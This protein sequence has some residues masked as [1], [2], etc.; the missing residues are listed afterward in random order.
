MSLYRSVV[1]FA[2]GLREYTKSGYE[3]ACKDF[4]PHDLEVQIP[5][6]VFL[7]TGGNSGIGKATALEIAKRGGTVHLVCRDQAPAEDARGEII[8]ESGNQNI[9]LH[10]VDLSDPKQI[11]KFV[12]N[13]KQEHKLHVLINNAGCMVN[14]R[15]LT[16]D[17]LE[18]NFAANT[19]GVYILT[20]GLIPVLEKE[21]DPR[22][23]TV[24]S[25]GMLVQKLNT[26]DLQ[27]ERTPFDGTMVY[28]QN[29]RQQ[30]V[31]T[32]RWA[33]GHPAIHFSSMHP[34][35]AD[36]PGVRQAMP[37]FHAR[38]GDR[39]RSEAQGADTMLWLALSSAAA[40]QPSGR[41]FQDRKP[42]ST[43]LP[44]ATASSSPAEE[45]KLIEILEQ[46]AQ[47]FK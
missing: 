2:K 37:G 3:S 44:L 25:G 47:T 20:T 46:L 38:F 26:N 11:W 42:V 19:L 29:K 7:V 33:Q 9:F 39:L 16:E 35:W 23:I 12:E 24:S 31:L 32:E 40:A 45:E 14:K 34:G 27:S 36:T 22:V 21:H 8:R 43:H 30:V 1:W 5:G 15:E 13:F 28:A 4:V 10:I 41:F 6:R 17:G 18:K